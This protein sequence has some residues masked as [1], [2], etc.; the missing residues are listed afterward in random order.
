MNPEG[1]IGCGNALPW[2]LRT[3]MRFFRQT[4]TGN[5]VL[6]GRRTFDSLGK[7]CLPDRYNV[8]ISHSFSL[9]PRTD[10]CTSAIGIEDGLFRAS[11]APKRFKEA[12]VIGGASMYEQ[13]A[14][15]VDRYLVT[16]VNKEVPDADTFFREAFFGDQSEWDL[17]YQG[18]VPESELDEAPFSIFELTSRRTDEVRERRVRAIE[19]ARAKSVPQ[20][21]RYRASRPTTKEGAPQ[22]I[23]MMF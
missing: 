7:K 9:F 16:V 2:R 4:T 17:S 11:L 19:E 21:P 5:V 12:F 22:S 20:V 15:Y 6:M 8:V 10:S 18:S 13:Y 3:D 1:A 14:P 23:A